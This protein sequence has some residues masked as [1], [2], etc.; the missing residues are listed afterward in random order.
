MGR[1]RNAGW[2]ASNL[3]ALAGIALGGWQVAATFGNPSAVGIATLIALQLGL[4]LSS[5]TTVLSFRLGN[6]RNMTNLEA[7]FLL[8]LV[9][10]S[11][12][13]LS[14]VSAVVVVGVM[15]G[16]VGILRR[17]VILLLGYLIIGLTLAR[18]AFCWLS[19]QSFSQG[20]RLNA[21]T[22]P[23]FLLIA[24]V[25]ASVVCLVS[26][27]SITEFHQG[28]ARERLI[29][30]LRSYGWL[31][32]LEMMMLPSTTLLA[33]H[34]PLLIIVILYPVGI[35]A[36]TARQLSALSAENSRD[37]LTGLGNRTQMEQGFQSMAYE[38]GG[39]TRTA[40]IAVLAVG[41]D[42]FHDITETLGYNAADRLLKEVGA[43]LASVVR[44]DVDK[45]GRLNGEVFSLLI[46]LDHPTVT[47]E[48]QLEQVTNRLLHCLREDFALAGVRVTIQATV[49]AALYPEHG[50]TAKVLLPRAE[51]ALRSQTEGG[52]GEL[53]LYNPESEVSSPAKLALLGELR[54][55][56]DKGQ[57]EV[58]YQPKLASET[59]VVTGAEA[60]VRWHHPTRGLVPPLEF[61]PLAET[62]GLIG[63][64]TWVVL[65]QALA[66]VRSWLVNQRWAVGV[67]V[68]LAAA[69]LMD[70]ST[71]ERIMAALA[72]H[73][74]PKELLTLEVT[75]STLI[76]DA[77]QAASVLAQL[78]H[79]G[80]RV[81][82][83]DYGTGY[84]SLSYLQKLSIDELK[85]DRAFVKNLDNGD[86][87]H[88][89][90]I[91]ET[92]ITLGHR[93]FL[94]VVAEGVETQAQL[95]ILRHAGCDVI[96]G[97]YYSGPKPAAE[98]TTW[99]QQQEVPAAPPLATLPRTDAQRRNALVCI[100]CGQA[101][102]GHR[103]NLCIGCEQGR[104]DQ[105]QPESSRR[106]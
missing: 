28:S 54:E 104:S 14:V 18:L 102:R 5:L 94:S 60:L 19:D 52:K 33:Q 6:V 101:L 67:S 64:L 17:L 59:G 99:M 11:P 84:S 37:P 53:H 45:V 90:A 49:G 29:T 55:A 42:Q 92:T 39:F 24:V 16:V 4:A 8:A 15:A 91:V 23:A 26:V 43:R 72:K 62:T 105:P 63:P 3:V 50:H 47:R 51:A 25:Y 78:R 80:V 13:W 32:L 40:N 87:H 96:Q 82:V 69:Q 74:V 22:L 65:D 98:L 89:L 44:K 36:L 10:V 30:H 83:D 2:L 75:E 100:N 1:T 106:D 93:L 56:I 76:Q 97:F 46:S 86:N 35:S 57:I 95:E 41:I 88:D 21:H 61:I 81:S 71:P 12:P 20:H 9:V 70:E 68:N 48:Q 58:F 31:H 77:A 66:Q 73:G 79:I 7:T 103:S 27:A 34:H 38:S 85:I